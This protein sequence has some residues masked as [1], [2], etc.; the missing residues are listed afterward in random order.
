MAEMGKGGRRN[1]KERVQ[2][3]DA[4]KIRK[5]NAAMQI[6]KAKMNFG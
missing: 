5:H 3:A 4:C 6:N 2:T 1:K